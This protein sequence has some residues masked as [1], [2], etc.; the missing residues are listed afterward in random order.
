MALVYNSNQVVTIHMYEVCWQLHQ[1]FLNVWISHYSL[2]PYSPSKNPVGNQ[3]ILNK[4]IYPTS[5]RAAI[6]QKNCPSAWAIGNSKPQ[7]WRLASVTSYCSSRMRVQAGCRRSPQP[8]VNQQ[9]G[10]AFPCSSLCC[11]ASI[12]YITTNCELSHFYC[13]TTLGP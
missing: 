9:V 3:H 6:Q 5:W 1:S 8:V 12:L 11:L 7:K 2:L 10:R 4:S 13:T